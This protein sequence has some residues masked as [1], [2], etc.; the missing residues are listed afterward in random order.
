MYGF[1]AGV[2]NILAAYGV[3]EDGKVKLWEALL[4]AAI[5]LVQA[6]FTRGDVMPMTTIHEAGL[7]ATE[8]HLRAA[9][10]TIEPVKEDDFTLPT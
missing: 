9:D 1:S 5:N 10:P 4:M 6:I 8:V 7:T 3:L 2:I